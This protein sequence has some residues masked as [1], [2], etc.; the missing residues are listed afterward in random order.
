[1]FID[2]SR[3]HFHSPARRKIY[4]DL[5]PEQAQEGFCA[6]LLQNMYGTRDAAANVADMVMDALSK[7][8]F[9]I[10][11]FNPCLRVHKTRGIRLFYHGDDF[12]FL[13]AEE[14]LQ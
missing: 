9:E 10:G 14:H 4:V 3:A 5:P 2:I 13:A 6:L 8:D 11:T 1:M 7:M 12:V